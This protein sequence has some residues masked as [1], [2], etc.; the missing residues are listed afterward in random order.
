MT[1]PHRYTSY[2]WPML[3]PAAFTVALLVIPLL[4][5]L[6]SVFSNDAHHW[7]SLGFS[8]LIPVA[9][10][11]EPTFVVASAGLRRVMLPAQ[12]LV[13]SL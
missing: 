9:R 8:F 4:L 11:Q 5:H 13:V 10:E 7:L 1:L 3:A 12:S 2:I 6:L